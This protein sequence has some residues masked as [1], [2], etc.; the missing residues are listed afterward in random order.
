M[1]T[2]VNS[3]LRQAFDSILMKN[4]K[5]HNFS[6][7]GVVGIINSALERKVGLVRLGDNFRLSFK[8]AAKIG[9]KDGCTNPRA[10]MPYDM[11]VSGS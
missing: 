10:S 8:T 2:Q 7:G 3:T 9:M 4:T 6:K 1:A 11:M 5:P